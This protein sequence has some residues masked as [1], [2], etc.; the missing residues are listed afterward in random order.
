M[1]RIPFLALALLA[2]SAL[3]APAFAADQAAAQPSASG[4]GPA[5][6]TA[7]EEPP[8]AGE[9]VVLAAR[10]KGQVDAPEPPVATYDETDIAALGAAS[11]SE[12][13]DRI[14]PQ[15][16]SGRGRGNGPPLVLVNGQRITNFREMRDYPPEA[17]KRVEVLPEE[18]ALR[19]GFPPDARVVNLILKDNFSNRRAELSRGVPTRGGFSV[20]ELEAT[21]LHIDGPRRL[22]VNGKIDHTTPLFESE[23]GVVQ[24]AASAPTVAGDPAPADYRSLI[25]DTTDYGFN[26]SW[27]KG[28]GK[29][30]LGG[31]ISLNGAAS[32][33]LSTSYSGL[34]L[35]RLTAPDGSS[36]LRTLADPLRRQTTT[37]NVQGGAGINTFLGLWQF[38]A[39]LDA[40]HSESTTLIDRRAD[41]SALV[42]AAAA[43]TLDITGPLPAVSSAGTDTASST[44]N[45]ATALATLIGRPVRLPAGE[46]V[47]T[48]R[49]GFAWSD[50][51]SRDT[52]TLDAAA[53]LRRGDL[54]AGLN[55]ALPLTSRREN[56]LPGLGD[57]TLNLSAGWNHL[58]DFGDLKDWSAG[59]T[60]TPAKPLT[61]GVTYIVNEAAPT[62]AQLGNP[63]VQTFNVPVYDYARGETALVTVTS[64]GNPLLAKERQRDWKFSANWQLPIASNSN[65]LVEYFRNHSNDVSANFPLLSSAIEAA[66]PGRVTRDAA[67]RLFAIDQRPVTFAEQTGARLRWGL[68]LSGALGKAAPQG[69]GG[70][71]RGGR[72]GAMMGMMGRPGGAQGRWHFGIFHTVQFDSQVLIAPGGPRLD[73]LNGDALVSG[74]TPRHSIEFNGGM[75][76]KAFGFFSQGTWTAPT[77]VRGGALPGSSDLRFG[78][79]TKININLFADLGRMPSLVEKAPLFRNSRVS[80]KFENLLDSRQK[81]TDASGAVPLSYQADYLDPRG[82]VITLELRKSF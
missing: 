77:T 72:G 23:R 36:A 69:W 73:L 64:G 47:L 67:G 42:A 52:R 58:S 62:L 75:F 7:Q 63:Q 9:I 66:F 31:S 48:L 80:L 15:T 24:T 44:T 68:N 17:I 25:A 76:Y 30:G 39:T 18:V 26:A 82:R 38:S 2:T 33:T 1:R 57:L 65:L 11:V 71:G 5:A 21:L 29:D 54:S 16:G 41:T 6:D 34:D 22:S 59:L 74:G 78:T 56:V 53:N 49:S 46:A 81:V 19:F 50:I 32:R 45:S 60:W 70:H 14:S 27:T 3:S 40:T 28:L 43:G 4:T 61:F 20:S 55:L 12:L 10:I 37:S 8:I 35:V 79:V 13:L 51:Q